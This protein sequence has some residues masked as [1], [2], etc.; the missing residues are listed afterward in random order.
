MFRQI[1]FRD[2]MEALAA[3]ENAL[4]A[5]TQQ[6]GDNV[7]RDWLDSG[8]AYSGF[9]I[10]RATATTIQVAPGRI[11]DAG[12]GFISDTAQ[13]ID[14]T[15]WLPAV[16]RRI[17]AVLALGQTIDTTPVVRN[18]LIDAETEEQQPRQIDLERLRGVQLSILAGAEGPSPIRPV[19]ASGYITIGW[20]TIGPTGVGAQVDIAM[21]P[22]TEVANLADA[23][24]G[25]LA[26]ND[27][28]RV[29]EAAIVNLR[30]Q[31]AHIL[32]QL[33]ELG[34]MSLVLQI[35][36]D[37]G[38]LKEMANLPD[39]RVDYG[40]DRFLTADESWT[41]W[42]GYQ[43]MV[44]EG[45][46]HA[47]M[48]EDVFVP[49]PLNPYDPNVMISPGGLML[50]LY[51]EHILL[52]LGGRLVERDAELRVAQYGT[53]TIEGRQMTLSRARMRY[54]EEYVVCL[55]STWWQQGD[56]D[57]VTGILRKDGETFFTEASD[58]NNAQRTLIRHRLT[59]YF[60]D[61]WNEKYWLYMSTPRNFTGKAIA[62]TFEVG[63]EYWCT[64][65]DLY[66]TALG[67]AGD[68]TL[69]LV[70]TENGK[71]ITDKIVSYVTVP[72]AQLKLGW[73][74]FPIE[75][76]FLSPST[77]YAI[78]MIT[79]GDHYVSISTNND[80]T[81]GTFFAATDDDYL[82]VSPNQDLCFRMMVA[83]F[84]TLRSSVELQPWNLDGGINSIDMI[85]PGVFFAQHANWPSFQFE[86]RIGATWYTMKGPQP[87]VD[88]PT[89]LA[90]LPVLLPV[91]ITYVLPSVFT[92]PGV[93]LA[94]AQI[95]VARPRTTM[96]HI[97]KR[98]T[99]AGATDDLTVEA[100]IANWN[101]AQHTATCVI[102]YGVTTSPNTG[103]QL[104]PAT[105]STINTG[106][107]RIRRKWT[108]VIPGGAAVQNVAIQF[109]TTAL[110]A[111]N[112]PIIEER[113]HVFT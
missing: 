4:Q 104:A 99:S 101:A 54:G 53:V 9:G 20:V 89:A 31:I 2:E 105:V 94:G 27:W 45:I 1:N 41:A 113:T 82:V 90:A 35:A 29:T 70:E 34:G 102:H 59:R 57:P 88:A 66:F 64:S 5:F 83:K 65:F 48:N 96:R 40:A 25:L 79:P 44:E 95:K 108:F 78:M 87:G 42:A 92:A 93:Q 85:L 62:Q 28:R 77:R 51:D 103:T 14:I 52:N 50:P 15:P 86:Y 76:A 91:R 55:N 81:M 8:R 49:A 69:L 106:L 71:P 13:T 46:R 39:V 36:K 60:A 19:V 80:Y 30:A 32:Q 12:R 11:Y 22:L 74:N 107:G 58:T 33:S 98:I 18:F 75:P 110:S 56:Y 97:S 47:H 6:W 23:F 24:A 10:T 111:N 61:L 16:G 37:V 26:L 84:R 73:T 17:L 43:A 72:R 100:D 67:A 109:D 3:D 21:E 68:V 112:V 63:A 7:V 38:R